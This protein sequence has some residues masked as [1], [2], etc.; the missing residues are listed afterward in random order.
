MN[1]LY[2]LLFFIV[3][4]LVTALILWAVHGST[5]TLSGVRTDGDAQDPVTLTMTSSHGHVETLEVKHGT[6]FTFKHNFK[7]NEG[8]VITASDPEC[9]ILNGSGTFTNAS[10]A[11][12][13]VECNDPKPTLA[14]VNQAGTNVDAVHL[15]LN[16]EAEEERS[17]RRGRY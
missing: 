12:V 11:N 7:K 5:Y 4:G 13:V 17:I 16:F 6:S 9:T 8:Y 3:A 15:L 14:C 10:I 2:V 1:I